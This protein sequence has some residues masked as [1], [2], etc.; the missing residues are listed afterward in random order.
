MLMIIINR[1]INISYYTS[2]IINYYI[3]Y[4]DES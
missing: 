1:I 4:Y 2:L 3:N